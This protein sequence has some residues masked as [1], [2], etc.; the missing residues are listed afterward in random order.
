M[1][2]ETRC[3]FSIVHKEHYPPFFYQLFPSLELGALLQ[4]DA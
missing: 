3:K 1:S 4:I 2:K